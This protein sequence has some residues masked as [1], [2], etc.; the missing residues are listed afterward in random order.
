MTKKIVFRWVKIFLLVYAVVGIAW[1]Y[2][3]DR[4]LLHPVKMDSKEAY[5]FDQPF[6]EL[7]LN[8]DTLTNLNVVQFKATDRPADSVAKG[9][10]LFF[11]GNSNNIAHDGPHAIELT[12]KGYEV[13]MM[14]YPGFGKSTGGRTE[15]EL[16]AYSLVFYKLARSRWKPAQIVL[17]GR[18]FGTGIAAQLASVRDCR[19][20][21]LDCPY[22]SMTSIFRRYLFLYPVGMML[23][24]HLPTNEYLLAVTAPITIFHGDEDWTIPYSNAR[25]LVPL[26]KPGDEFITISG[27]GHNDLHNSPIFRAKLDSVLHL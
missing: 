11:H 24:Y 9:V 21:I 10:V 8:Y 13:W 23:H 2:G 20:L 14:D 6:T 27:A 12:S 15:K 17:Y 16:Y 4:L 5:N 25:R 1:Y 19:R 18:S 26:L 22:Y 7:N 3:Q